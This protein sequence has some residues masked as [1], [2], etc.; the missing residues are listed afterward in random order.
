MHGR[1]KIIKFKQTEIN[2]FV[3]YLKFLPAYMAEHKLLI[4]GGR[5]FCNDALK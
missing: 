4:C 2:P 5:T 3:K 1:A